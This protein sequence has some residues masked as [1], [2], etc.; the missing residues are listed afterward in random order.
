MTA[1]KLLQ[2]F[3]FP[4]RCNLSESEVYTHNPFGY[5]YQIQHIFSL[6]ISAKLKISLRLSNL[7]TREIISLEEVWEPCHPQSG[8]TR[9]IH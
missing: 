2:L 7:H 9:K 4:I 8:Q 6:L 3:L 5:A 1:K